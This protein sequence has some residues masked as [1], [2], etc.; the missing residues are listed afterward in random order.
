M[1]DKGVCDGCIYYR[2]FRDTPSI[3]TIC[4]FVGMT[5]NCRIVIEQNN[6]GIKRDSCIC[7]VTKKKDKKAV[8]WAWRKQQ[9]TGNTKGE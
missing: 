4:D 5:G 7:K 2:N 6:G 3:G 9:K 8:G 1:K